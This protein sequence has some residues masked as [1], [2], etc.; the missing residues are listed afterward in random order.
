MVTTRSQPTFS[1]VPDEFE[2]LQELLE[3]AVIVPLVVRRDGD[4]VRDVADDV[5][6]LDGDLHCIPISAHH[7]RNY[8][9]LLE[10]L[11]ELS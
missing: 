7:K 5:K 4:T 8:D 3:E 9:S 1:T 6:L 10:K 11:C 2:V